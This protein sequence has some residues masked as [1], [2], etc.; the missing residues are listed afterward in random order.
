MISLSYILLYP[1]LSYMANSM[2]AQ[3]QTYS[4]SL[5]IFSNLCPS[6]SDSQQH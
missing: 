3:S 5:H 2:T 4:S 6:I 1:A